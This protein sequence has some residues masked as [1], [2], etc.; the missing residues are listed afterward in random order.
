MNSTTRPILVRYGGAALFT[1]LAVLLRRFLDP[2]LGDQQAFSTAYAAVALAVWFGGSRPGLLAV[3]LGFLACRWLFVEP[4]QTLAVD[5]SRNLI[6]LLCYLLSCGILVGVGQAL[7]AAR[8]NQ[9]AHTDKGGS[10]GPI[11]DKPDLKQTEQALDQALEQVRIVTESMAAAVTRCG[12]DLRY[13]WVSKVYAEMLGRTPEQI[14]GRPI[15][16]VLGRQSFDQLRPHFE[17]ALAGEKVSYEEEVD[18]P[19]VGRRWIKAVYTPTFDVACMADG[20]VAVVL[21]L[22]DRKRMEEALREG[23]ARLAAHLSERVQFETALQETDRSKDRFLAT[24]AHELR[25]PLVPLRNAV[26]ILRRSDGDAAERE[27]LLAMM[28]RQ[29]HQ[30]TRLIDDLL[31]VSRISQGKVQVRKE[32]VELAGIVRSALE[33]ARPFIESQGHELSVTLPAQPVCLDAD[34]TRL[35]Q[36]VANLLH[37]AAKYTDSGGRIW[38]TAQRQGNDAVLSV[39][40]TGIGIAA[41]HLP[42]LFAMFS[43]AAPALARSHGGLGIGLALVRGLVELHG[44]TVEAHSDGIGQGSEFLVRLP[45]VDGSLSSVAMPTEDGGQSGGGPRRRILVVDDNRDV[46]ETMAAIMQMLGHETRMA[47]DGLDGLQAAAEFRPDVVILDIGLPMM[48]GYEAAR[49]LRQQPWGQGVVLIALTGWGQEEDK[50]RALE[51]GFDHHLTKPI[52]VTALEKLLAQIKPLV[53]T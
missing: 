19:G 21:D 26:E 8:P 33:T 39:R 14:V 43:Q 29:L 34:P 10:A 51:A 25:N 42:Q 30:L 41:E 40:D 44:G 37:N 13:Q 12:R 20:W 32:R 3:V 9:L 48:N 31:D 6:G 36:V 15:L 45:A 28:G 2:W 35:A 5:G 7:P 47:Y 38:L 50:R 49:Q 52:G 1:A 23:E 27:Q 22:T 46:A 18:Y 11:I 16:E 17:Q 53:R 4:R 24:L